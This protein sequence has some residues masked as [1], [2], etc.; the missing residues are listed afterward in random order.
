LL[1]SREHPAADVGG[2][3]NRLVAGRVLLPLGLSKVVV[4]GAAGHDERVVV[5]LTVRELEPFRRS[6][7]PTASARRESSGRHLVEQR[8]K[9]MELALVDEG[10]RDRPLQGLRGVESGEAT[11]NDDD[12]SDDATLHVSTA[13]VLI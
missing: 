11:P 12:S 10:H 13:R 4:L 1:E 2:V 6:S 5:E 8:L 7:R 3:F 9:Q